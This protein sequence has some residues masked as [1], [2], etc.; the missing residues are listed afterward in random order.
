MKASKVLAAALG[1]LLGSATI[2]SAGVVMSETAIASGPSG[3][4]IER[5]TIYIQGDKQK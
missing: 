5:R 2:V 1:F 3:K 4:G